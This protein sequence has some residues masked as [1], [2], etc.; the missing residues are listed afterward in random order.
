[1]EWIYLWE[2]MRRYGFGPRYLHW[3]QLLYRAPK[4]WVRTND[5][6]SETFALYRGMRQGCVL[7]LSLFA[8]ALEP[9]AILIRESP[10]V[11]GLRVGRLEEKLSLYADD[12]PLYLNDE[13][14]FPFGSPMEF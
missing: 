13:G 11:H 2:V 5:W 1:M 9:L 3:L 12:A 4:A 6:L 10:E 7:S 14:P 8:L